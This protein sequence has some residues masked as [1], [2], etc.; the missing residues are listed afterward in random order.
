MKL[1]CVFMDVSHLSEQPAKLTEASKGGKME[2]LNQAYNSLQD[3]L[4][5]CQNL[6]A[7]YRA[8]ISKKLVS[9]CGYQVERA[10]E[11]INSMTPRY[12]VEEKQNNS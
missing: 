8:E 4:M 12:F 3:A 5:A 6:N 9:Q 2:V 11:I 1:W 10:L 7:E